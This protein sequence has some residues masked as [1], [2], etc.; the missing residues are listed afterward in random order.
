MLLTRMESLFLT[1]QVMIITMIIQTIQVLIFIV[2][3]II[4]MDNSKEV[5]GVIKIAINVLLVVEELSVK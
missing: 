3:G 1:A 5:Y 4:V 2:I